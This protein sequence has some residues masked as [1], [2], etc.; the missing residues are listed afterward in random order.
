MGDF[1]EHRGTLREVLLHGNLCHLSVLS[2][3]E[4]VDCRMLI[5]VTY[6]HWIREHIKDVSEASGERLLE[7]FMDLVQKAG[8]ELY[9][10]QEEAI[11]ELF[12]GHHVILNTPTG[13]GKSMVALALHFQSLAP[14]PTI[15][16]H[17]SHQ[18][19]GQ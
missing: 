16:L 5:A 14:W 15:R 1:E 19:F 8:M 7:G 12:D 6:T 11:L 17:L 18:G 2:C 10:A 4:P 3:A 9:P 13:S